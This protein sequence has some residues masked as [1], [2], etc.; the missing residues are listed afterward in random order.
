MTLHVDE[1]DP[2][3]IA[4]GPDTRL[5]VSRWD[6]PRGRSLVS[7]APLYRA[8][9]GDWRLAHSAVCVPPGDAARLTA[10]VL[11]VAASIDGAPVDPMPTQ[12][13]RD[14]SRMP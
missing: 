2:T 10:A 13:S 8:R 6:T 1:L 9:G 7:I 11:A 3:T 14:D 5:V 4:T 12:Q